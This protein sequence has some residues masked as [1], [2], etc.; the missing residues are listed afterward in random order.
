[1]QRFNTFEDFQVTL[2]HLS[3]ETFTVWTVVDSLY[4]D[5]TKSQYKRVTYK[6]AHNKKEEAIKSRGNCIRSN[7]QYQ[8]K[9]CEAVVKFNLK[10]KENVNEVRMINNN[11]NHDVNE[12]LYK[13]Y[14]QTRK[15]TEA[16][17]KDAWS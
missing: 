9:G 3:Q 16:K 1:M 6:C 14:V 10:A 5:E 2:E 15:L 8:A 7:Q 12:Q 11:H 17:E 4:T 13:M